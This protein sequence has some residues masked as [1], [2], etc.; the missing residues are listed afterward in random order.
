M[1][2]SS[3]QV[4]GAF[5]RLP[6]QAL[7]LLAPDLGMER[8]ARVGRARWPLILALVCAL[9]AGVAEAVRVDARTS[10]LATLEQSDQLKT[11][12]DRQIDDQ[13]RN[14]ER[15]F[16]VKRVAL[17][18]VQAPVSFVGFLIA[19]YAL[20]WFLRG[21]SQGPA[22]LAVAG[23]ALL[24][25][26]LADLLSGGAALMH[27][28][29]EPSHAALIPRTLSDLGAAVS[30]P[31]G[32]AVGKLL[33][34]VDFFSLWAALLLAFGLQSAASLPRARPLYGTLAA[35]VLWRLLTTVAVGG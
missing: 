22:M 6:A 18:L 31:M 12:S 14:D 17:S 2:V 10:T 3:N 30:L 16:M 27:F 24:P 25:G 19:L 28:S 7:A 5:F 32:A 11:M 1:P 8:V 23:A 13:V 20:S 29:I 15:A 21:R 4:E 9:A 35:W 33:T 34:A 26:A